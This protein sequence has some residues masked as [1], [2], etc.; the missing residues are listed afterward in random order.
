MVSQT[1]KEDSVPL[2]ESGIIKN[3]LIYSDIETNPPIFLKK[4]LP[5]GNLFNH[6]SA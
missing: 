6:T 4:R 1:S 5:I 3:L 2:N